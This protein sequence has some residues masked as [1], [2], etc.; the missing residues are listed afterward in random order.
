[1]MEADLLLSAGR[2]S[3]IAAVFACP[4]VLATLLWPL[5]QEVRMRSCALYVEPILLPMREAPA[6][7]SRQLGRGHLKTP[8]SPLSVGSLVQS[9]AQRRTAG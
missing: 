7:A 1:M 8:A 3:C 4:C 2:H 5:Q 9:V 6:D